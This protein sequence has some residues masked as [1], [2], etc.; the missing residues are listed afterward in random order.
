MS[1]T[2]CFER[3]VSLVISVTIVA[4]LIAILGLILPSGVSAGSGIWTSTGGPVV[5]GGQV[6]AIVVHPTIPNTVYAAVNV[7]TLNSAG[8]VYRTTDG[9]ANWSQVY[10]GTTQLN[11]LAVTST[12]VYAAGG[13]NYGENII[14]KSGNSGSNWTAVFTGTDSNTNDV[15]NAIAINPSTTNIVYAAGAEQAGSTNSNVVYRTEDGGTSWTQVFNRTQDCCGASLNALVIHPT[16]PTTVYVAGGE[17]GPDSQYAVIYKTTNAGDPS[18]VWTQV[19]STTDVSDF[20]ALVVDPN[21]NM[22]YVGT[23][24]NGPNT[25]YSGGDDGSGWGQFITSGPQAG[26]RLALDLPNSTLYASTENNRPYRE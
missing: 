9:A 20:T 3:H 8:K 7:D 10:A 6:N 15:F 26:Y 12:L 16:T 13:Q 24:G 23:E 1:A 17:K 21:T 4:A 2:N 18:P 19:Y 25:V 11:A 22:L 5:A 14:V